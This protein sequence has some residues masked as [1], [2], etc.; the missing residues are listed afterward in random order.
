MNQKE[1]GQKIKQLKEE[2]NA[3]IL[4]H[5]YQIEEVQDIAD[6]VGDSFDLA[7][8]AAQAKEGVI[9]FCGVRFM[10]ESAKILSPHKTVI[11]P[12][13]DAGC[14]LADMAEVD[15]IREMKKKYPQ[16]AFVAYVNTSAVVKAEVDVCCTSSNALQVVESLPNEQIVFLPDRNLGSYVAARTS[17][18]IIIWEGYCETHDQVTK[19][20][21]DIAR[22]LHR[23][24]LVAVHPECRSE[25]VEAADY[26]G[27]TAGILRYVRETDNDTFI[28][29][30]EMGILHRLKKENPNKKFIILSPRLICPDMKKIN[31]DK[32]LNSLAKLTPTIDVPKEIADKAKRSLE[33]ML[34]IK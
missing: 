16:A 17:K 28:I 32:I 8:K 14:S 7:Q 19:E 10:A 12:S 2:Q 24:A 23:G 5:N 29:G 26:A 15:A 6:F 21:V 18:E 27:G 33:R 11:M 25:V 3:I 22:S 30:T 1:L 20:E 34:A 13:E 31:L 4:A 9:I